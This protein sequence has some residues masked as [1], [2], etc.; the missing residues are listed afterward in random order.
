[1]GNETAAGGES[2]EK[3]SEGPDSAGASSQSDPILM[4][5][6]LVDLPPGSRRPLADEVKPRTSGG[7][8]SIVVPTIRLHC[9]E[10]SCGGIRFFAPDID[11]FSLQ[12]GHNRAWLTY[13][14]RDCANGYRVYAL[15]FEASAKGIVQL[16]KVGEFPAF[17]PPLP[18]RLLTLVG[19]DREYFL[20]GRRAESQGMGVGAYAY[21]RRVV[22]NQKNRLLDETIRVGTT[23]NVD[24]SIVEALERAKAETQFKKAMEDVKDAVPDVLKIRGLNPFTLLHHAL[25]RGIHDMNDDECLQVAGDIRIVLAEL[26]DRMSTALKNERELSDAVTRLNQLR[27]GQSPR[28]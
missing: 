15:A 24:K 21:Y 18:S 10:S 7:G 1:M 28:E 20:R 22:E 23:L 12:L 25:S 5:E 9:A 13:V 11:N 26:A 27:S 3:D 16:A 19:P 14:C 17:G 8:W 6:F 4:A 2:S